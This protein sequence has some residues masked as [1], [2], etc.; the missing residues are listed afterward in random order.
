MAHP[1]LRLAKIVLII[2]NNYG[3]N[4]L[5]TLLIAIQ[6]HFKGRV[7][8]VRSHPHELGVTS[9]PKTKREQVEILRK[10][11]ARDCVFIAKEFVTE[12]IATDA[13]EKSEA[14]IL[15]QFEAQLLQYSEF[16]KVRDDVFG[17][18]K[19][20]YSGKASKGVRDDI[21]M[22]AQLCFLGR[23]MFDDDVQYGEWH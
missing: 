14:D 5:A 13:V 6:A 18:E 11:L 9:T 7:C 21:A 17:T 19:V 12:Y 1:E 22:A 16:R 10:H 2:E 8:E 23:R 4:I 3:K 15:S 20:V